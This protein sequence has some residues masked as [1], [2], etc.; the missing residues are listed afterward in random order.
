MAAR[1]GPGLTLF[2]ELSAADIVEAIARDGV[3]A[4]LQ[5]GSIAVSM[6]MLDLSDARAQVIADLEARGI[7]VTA[8][9]LLDESDGY[10]LNADNADQATARYRELAAFA[11]DHGLRLPRVGLDIEPPKTDLDALMTDGLPA[12]VRMIRSRRSKEH[13]RSAE[14]AYAALSAAIADSGRAVESYCV[15]AIADEVQ[16]GTTLLRRILGIVD[17]PGSAQVPMAYSTYFG[18]PL[19]SSYLRSS[20]MPAIGITGGGVFAE[21]DAPRALD[22]PTVRSQ[23]DWAAAW[24]A[25]RIY[26]FSL[27]GC[28]ASGMLSNLA[29]WRPEPRP[30]RAREAYVGDVIRALLRAALRSEP[31]L[32]RLRPAHP[33]DRSSTPGPARRSVPAA[34]GGP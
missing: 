19:A 16:A 27:E 13:I 34:A 3:C 5:A 20:R 26:V 6:A 15:P 17:V 24:G 22:W 4:Q 28:V 29:E 23:L 11:A 12:L 21:R 31:L 9:L 33:A 14:V 25:E 1:V 32:D 8:W 18:A 30:G 7:D 2:T 10:W